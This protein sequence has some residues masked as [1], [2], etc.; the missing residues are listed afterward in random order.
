MTPPLNDHDLLIRIDERVIKIDKF[1]ISHDKDIEKLKSFKSK[2]VG[3]FAL[4][5]L[6]GGYLFFI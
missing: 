3:S 2:C 5:S 6:F 4:F 1:L